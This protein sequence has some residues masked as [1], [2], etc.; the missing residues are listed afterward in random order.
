MSLCARSRIERAASNSRRS[1]AMARVAY[2]QHRVHSGPR[3]TSR[4]SFDLHWGRTPASDDSQAVHNLRGVERLVSEVHGW[5]TPI[6]RG[7]SVA[8]RDVAHSPH[9]RPRREV[10]GVDPQLLS[11]RRSRRDGRRGEVAY[12]CRP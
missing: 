12:L 5:R 6:G 9:D 1:R 8:S 3:V 10:L 7:R 11:M 2:G 4:G